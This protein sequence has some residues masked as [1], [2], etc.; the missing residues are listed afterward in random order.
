MSSVKIP[1]IHQDCYLQG[2]APKCEGPLQLILSQAAG[3]SDLACSPTPGR[4]GREI[5][6]A[7]VVHHH[8]VS[9]EHGSNNSDAKYWYPSLEGQNEKGLR[10]I[11]RT[12]VNIFS[13][14]LL[15]LLTCHANT[16]VHQRPI[17]L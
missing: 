2:A 10:C 12:N 1:L 9:I 7:N 15:P 11:D 14:I 8:D 5:R 3:A 4:R 17:T 16:H 6:V 13:H